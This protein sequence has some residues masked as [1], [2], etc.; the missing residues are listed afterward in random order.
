MTAVRGTAAQRREGDAA[1]LLMV[2]A[3]RAGGTGVA[4]GYAMYLLQAA[5]L[6]GRLYFSGESR[7]RARLWGSLVGN[8]V[9][10]IIVIFIAFWALADAGLGPF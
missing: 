2:V 9:L 8:G 4:L 6:N 3:Y 5:V 10:A 7:T 1:R